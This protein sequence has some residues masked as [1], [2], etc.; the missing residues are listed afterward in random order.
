MEAL[1]S[2][3]D[4]VRKSGLFDAEYYLV[5][6]P[7]VAERNID[8]LVHY[9]EE[10]AGEGR[11][12]YPDF[13]AGFYLE[14]C[15]RRGERPNNPLLH[16]IRIGNA[17][18]FKTRV[19]EPGREGRVI[20]PPPATDQLVKPPILVAIEVLGVIGMPEGTS[21]LSVSGWA[22]AA[23]PIH[24]ITIS[25]GGQIVGAATYGLA[26]PDV[27][28]LYPDRDGAARCGFI[29]AVDLPS[30]TTGA[31]EPLLTVR[32]VDGEIGENP[33]PVEIPPQAED[34]TPPGMAEAGKPAMQLV[35]DEAAVDRG[36]ILRIDGWVVCVVQ[37][38]SV[39]A[40]IDGARIGKAEFGRVRA[41]I[42]KLH[43]D[44][45]NSRFSGVA[46]VADVSL[47]GAGRKTI[48]IRATARGGITSVATAPV[49]ILELPAAP[50]LVRD[51]G[52]QY[53]CEEITLTPTGWIALRG[54]VVCASPAES[55][56]VIFDGTEIGRAEFGLE[57]PDLGNLFPSIAHARQPGF[58]FAA[59]TGK[60]VA[61][62]HLVTLR[63]RREDGQIHEAQVPVIAGGRR[64]PRAAQAAGDPDLQLHVDS[65]YLIGGAAEAP[66]RGNLEIS[67]WALAK[68]GVAVIEI[69]IDGTAVVR[70]DYGLRRLD[71]QA[72]FPDWDDA[73]A[74]GYQVLLPHRILPNGAHRV[75]VTLRDKS[76]GTTSTEFAI[77]VEELTDLPGPW[78]LR[79]KMGQ[80]EIDLYRRILE[81]R[82][83]QPMFAVMLPVNA[84]E[85]SLRKAGAT[86]DSIS[87]QAYPHWRL[88]IVP[89][90][91]SKKSGAI[92]DRLLAG[93]EGLDDRA[94]VVG[95]LTLRA[96]A[97]IASAAG[98]SDGATGG[99]VFF[100]VL[101]V[102]DELGVDAFLEM[103]IAAA[104]HA[105]ADFFYSDE[106][107]RNPASGAVDAFF[108]PQWSPDLMAST[109]YVGRVWCARADLIGSVA[110][111]SEILLGHGEYDL[112]L[113]CTEAATAVRHVP[114][115]LCERAAAAKDDPKQSKK[116]LERMLAR[117]GIAGEICGGPVSG[118]YRLKRALTK[119]G[120]VSILIPT[121]AAQGMIETCLTTLR[122]VTA[123]RDYEIICIEN[124]AAKDRKWRGW[125]RRN[126]D[127]VIATKEAFNWA[128]FSN[129]AAAAATGDY[130][131]FLND[132]IEFADPDWLEAMLAEAQR[133][134]VG[135]VG[136]RLL[137]PDRRVQ[138]AGMFLAALGQGRHAFRYAAEDDPGYFGL[139][140]T[141]RNV[142][143]VTGACLLTRRETFDAL[144]G[145]NQS[146][147]II[148]NDVDYCL[149]S[150]RSGLFNVYTPHATLIHHEA[151]SR[152]AL[153]DDYDAAVFDSKW[154]NLFL[155]G[156]PFFNPHLSKNHDDFAVDHEPTQLVVTGRPLLRRDDIRRILV[157]KLDHIGDCV[158]A[159]RAIRRLRQHFPAAHISVLTSQASRPVWSLEPDVEATIE[160][161]FFHPRSADGEVA[162]TEADWQEL[163][164]RLSGE[165][166]DLA[167]DLRK[168]TETRPV[169]QYSG[170]RWLAGFDFRNQFGW[171]DIALEWSGDQLYARKH[172]H[173]ADDL[174]NLVDA[175]AAACESDRA[176]I[177]ARPTATP[178]APTAQRRKTPWAG[179]LVCVHL[180]SGNDIKQWPIEYFAVVIDRLVEMDGAR[181][182]L[183]GAAGDEA[184]AAALLGRLRHPRA[185]SSLVGKATLD[186][187]P[188]L[189]AGVALFLGSDS[190]PKH[191]AAGLGVP[192]VGI[193]GGTVDFREWGPV[194]PSAIALARDMVCSPCYLSKVEDCHRGVACL[195]QLAPGRVYEA[196][197]RLLLLA[198]TAQ[199]ALR[200]AS[201]EPPGAHAGRRAARR[202]VETAAQASRR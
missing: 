162:H 16:Y 40:F 81:H 148:N 146:H 84:D 78:A 32:T 52:F 194:G 176:V 164:Q 96:L 9:L 156:D 74:S 60:P 126:A 45:P 196:C 79:R 131:L 11:N 155:A 89:Q 20:K 44:Y 19:E 154:R 150:W 163:R 128:R 82:G 33:L 138:H 174:V 93:N 77:T 115:V 66:V 147:G 181:I 142:I 144:G 17:R 186:E 76:G 95:N 94:E 18:G 4:E 157:V 132:D 88:F 59:Q 31:I 39:E 69:A 80:A 123:Y 133:P 56:V 200:P 175:I 180:M 170:A 103:A 37:I 3:Y 153:D 125:L 165:H 190:G 185:V 29:L 179:P 92:R 49:Q 102:G 26:R 151:I 161:D 120:L 21:R 166:F 70:A 10:G 168:H 7:D 145:F 140:L 134:E 135:V 85:E 143:A 136:P 8:P 22:L 169:L 129:L 139:S 108:K 38:E 23:A 152:A 167:V 25:L 141:Q 28:R 116:A 13:D 110:G 5:T 191:I 73:L 195:Q 86:I 178:P 72:A 158:I 184:V 160:F 61:G 124:I 183:I 202:P 27:A 35:V 106:R 14:Q 57:R 149:R 90:G 201:R 68:A 48:A 55:V 71:I 130:L 137:Y 113:R 34:A 159:F 6:Y 173:N 42:E 112:V 97:G 119:P 127:R 43:P 58:T 47:Y 177:A 51:P 53:H 75:L 192:T 109:N 30:L 122:R 189:L 118:T 193:H 36:G 67:G 54:W 188:G 1:F 63:I 101:S 99:E 2:D 24:E 111:P 182:V 12:P 83:R 198:A 64:T 114:A 65:P 62:E 15:E 87:L 100:T 121:C 46:L 171:L 91:A 104:M 107:C 98:S 105:E 199:G 197:R 172:Q 41:D 117:R 187:L 50:A